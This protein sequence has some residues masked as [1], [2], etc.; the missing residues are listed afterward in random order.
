MSIVPCRGV[1]PSLDIPVVFVQ[2]TV[3]FAVPV[4]ATGWSLGLDADTSTVVNG[5][6]VSAGGRSSRGYYDGAGEEG[7]V[8][9]E[10]MVPPFA[11]DWCKR[12]TSN[13]S[14]AR[15]VRL[16]NIHD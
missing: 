7:T 8:E 14:L 3:R 6:G 15:S 2:V 13:L 9:G 11:S 4:A 12:T 10:V 16:R 1:R 5:S